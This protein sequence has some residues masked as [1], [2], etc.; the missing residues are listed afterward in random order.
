MVAAI[1]RLFQVVRKTK[2][3]NGLF[4]FAQ[5]NAENIFHNNGSGLAQGTD[6]P[7]QFTG[8]ICYSYSV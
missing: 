4:T 2:I 5:G 8:L 1:G 6:S 3:I 7:L